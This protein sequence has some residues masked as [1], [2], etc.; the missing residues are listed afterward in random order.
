[1][2]LAEVSKQLAELI[3]E[4]SG[5]QAVTHVREI[6]DLPAVIVAPEAYT[7]NILGTKSYTAKLLVYIVTK[8][9]GDNSDVLNELGEIAGNISEAIGAK[10]WTA[11]AVALDNIGGRDPLPA[12]R[13]RVTLTVKE[14]DNE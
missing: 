4:S 13:A 3:T 10:E 5:Q 8:D 11:E 12:L 14:T 2:N 9:P 7:L 6:V 1:M